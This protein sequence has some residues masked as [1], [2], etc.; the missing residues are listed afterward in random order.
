MKPRKSKNEKPAEPVRDPD[1]VG[2]EAAM[3]RAAKRAHRRAVEHGNAVAVFKDGKVVWVK[4]DVETPSW[5]WQRHDEPGEHER[6]PAVVDLNVRVKVPALKKLVD[7]AASGIGAVAGSMLAPWKARQKAKARIIEA[8]SLRLIAEAQVEAHRFL[9]P[10]DET[11]QGARGI[12]PD[13]IAQRTEFQEKKRQANIAATIRGAAAE[14]GD[15]K[16]P[17]HDPD[18]DWTARFFNCVQ[19]VSS[20]DMRKLWTKL[21]SGE[22]EEPGRTSLRTLDILRNLTKEDARIFRDICD[23]TIAD[24]I[25]YP[26][27]HQKNHRF[28][29]YANA[30]H[31]DSIGLINSSAKVKVFDFEQGKNTSYIRY[32][33]HLLEISKSDAGNKVEIPVIW[34][35]KPGQELY[36]AMEHNFHMDYLE[37]FSEFLHKKNYKLSYARIVEEFPGGVC[38]RDP[39]IPIEPESKQ[40]RTAAP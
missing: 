34:I 24:S 11:G 4:A 39:F 14:L 21:L 18:P 26:A 38:R 32:Q 35:T 30:L 20:E 29:V 40:P 33:D 15:R 37:A 16:V 25:F 31:L 1:L 5:R 3:H 17:E 2:A 13:V 19:D 7:Y 23:F 10:L 27:E 9:V 12:G 6:K 36:R 8:D 28:F 22:V